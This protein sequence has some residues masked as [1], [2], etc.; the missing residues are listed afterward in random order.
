MQIWWKNAKFVKKNYDLKN[1]DK[2]I[3]IYCL[4]YVKIFHRFMLL[5]LSTWFCEH[6]IECLRQLSTKKY[7]KIELNPV[8]LEIFKKYTFSLTFRIFCT[9]FLVCILIR[10]KIVRLSLKRANGILFSPNKN[11][12]VLLFEKS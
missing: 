9:L 12:F 11:A 4:P 2:C 6:N 3:F 1:T 5:E 10:F 7:Q 8:F